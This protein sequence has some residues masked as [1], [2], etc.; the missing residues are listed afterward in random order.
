MDGATAH[1][2]EDEIA[3]L[4]EFTDRLFPPCCDLGGGR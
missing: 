3:R 4:R 1:W 2:M